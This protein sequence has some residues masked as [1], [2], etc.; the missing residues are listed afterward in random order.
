M[1]TKT[2]FM[3]LRQLINLK[4]WNLVDIERYTIAS[5]M[6]LN[7]DLSNEDK[8]RLL[9]ISMPTFVKK[10]KEVG[11]A[12]VKPRNSSKEELFKLLSESP[13]NVNI[14][15]KNYAITTLTNYTGQWIKE[16]EKNLGFAVSEIS[17][18]VCVYLYEKKNR[19][20]K[21]I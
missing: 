21:V 16:Q 14:I 15:V 5:M 7:K 2:K 20:T 6:Y 17:T 18:G 13:L 9:G 1:S 4:T 10:A 12:V 8:A 11:F 3:V 19:K